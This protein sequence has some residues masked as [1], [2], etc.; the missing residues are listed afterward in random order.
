[1]SGQS[2]FAAGL[3]GV[4]LAVTVA[5]GAACDYID[6]DFFE[7]SK[8]TESFS[9]T[10]PLKAGDRFALKNTNGYVRVTTWDR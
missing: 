10:L 3:A 2:K 6:G 7:G 9:K 5:V 1:M 4:F 8:H